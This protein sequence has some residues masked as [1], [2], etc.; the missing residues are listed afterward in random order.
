M[1]SPLPVPPVLEHQH[2]AL[3]SH[4]AFFTSSFPSHIPGGYACV[5]VPSSCLDTFCFSPVL[6]QKHALAF[7]IFLKSLIIYERPFSQ[8]AAK[9]IELAC[10]QSAFP[11]PAKSGSITSVV[12]ESK[13]CQCCF[14]VCVKQQSHWQLLS[15]MS[16]ITMCRNLYI[17]GLWEFR[18]VRTLFT[19]TAQ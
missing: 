18:T 1:G 8:H 19:V 10:T 11:E 2:R 16:Q 3:F 17:L 4:M 12:C 15:N 13:S 7:N 9:D 6:L 5:S 14:L